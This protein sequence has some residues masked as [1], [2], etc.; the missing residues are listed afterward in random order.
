MGEIVATCAE[1][2]ESSRGYLY[3]GLIL[4][5]ITGITIGELCALTWGS[6]SFSNT[7]TGITVIEISAETKLAEE[8]YH[9]NELN[10]PRRRTLPLPPTVTKLY[11]KVKD[12]APNVQENAPFMRSFK[13]EAR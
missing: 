11:H 9:I 7:Y 6:F 10:W 3:F 12:N 8:V 2:L 1:N 4:M 13:N 5:L